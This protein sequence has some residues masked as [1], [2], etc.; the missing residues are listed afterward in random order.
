MV[1]KRPIALILLVLA[2]IMA[3][4]EARADFADGVAAYEAGKFA[5]AYENWLP[6][7]E[8]G[9]PDAQLALGIL[10]ENGRGVAR[11]DRQA[12][13]W[14]TKAAE[15]GHPGAQFNLGNMYKQGRGVPEDPAL[16]VLW[17]TLAADKGLP[18][19][20]LNLGVAYHLGE[21]V[22]RDSVRAF[23]LF[24]AAA[25]SDI[26]LAQFSAGY[27]YE[28]GIGTEPDLD[29]ARRLYELAAKGG[30]P[31]AAERLAAMDAAAAEASEA[32]AAAAVEEPEGNQTDIAAAE[33]PTLAG[34]PAAQLQAS[35]EIDMAE[36]VP[37]AVSTPTSD[38]ERGGW[39]FIQLAA[40]LT[41]SR[42]EAAW[43]EL[44][45][46]YPDLLGDLPHRVHK[47]VLSRDASTVYGLQ[48]GPLP[49]AQEA[50]A[51]CNAL[52]SRNA[53]CFLVGG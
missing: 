53:E 11:D 51:V 6:L 40:F 15:A 37:S 13:D 20:M 23:E 32:V 9:N 2:A 7:A 34:E 5:T 41:E 28:F 39:P 26:P 8:A 1:L 44:A 27:A 19:A 36:A 46:R 21:G 16:A 22:A 45:G 52:R 29:E 18:G 14:Y 43:G 35:D 33:S 30:V 10:Y 47:M 25:A 12:A 24:T 17:W 31:K 50:Q 49:V 38:T 48:A 42:A 3:G 4:P